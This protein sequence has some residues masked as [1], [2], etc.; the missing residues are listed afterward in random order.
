[1]SVVVPAHDEGPLVR[2]TLERMLGSAAAG[3][4]DV[5]VV[6][7]GCSDDTAVQAALPGVR[8]VEIAERSKTAALDAG[9]AVSSTFPRAYVDADVDISTDALRAVA[10]ALSAESDARVAAPRLR[11]DASSS[12]APVRAYYAIWALSEYRAA[13]HVGSGFYAVNAAG[14]E[15]WGR[16]PGVIADDRF[17]QQ[18]FLPDERLCLEEHSFTVQ[19]SRDMATHIAR[20]ARIER[21]NAELPASAQLAE[22]ATAGRRY[23]TL[24]ARVATRPL[25]WPCLPFYVYGFGAAKLQARRSAGATAWARDES[26]RTAARA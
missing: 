23:T 2:R 18:R 7:N 13:G 15:R 16:F 11:V 6:A 25:L 4:F 1:M 9:D 14:R 5:V 19:A 24:L 10:R 26:V 3:E 20:G 17:V 22:Q 12:S 8:V 21:G